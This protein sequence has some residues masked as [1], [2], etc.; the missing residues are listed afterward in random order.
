MDRYSVQYTRTSSWRLCVERSG[1]AVPLDQLELE[2]VAAILNAD[3]RKVA[4][5]EARLVRPPGRP[6]HAHPVGEQCF[7]PRLSY[8]HK[9]TEECH[10]TTKP[11]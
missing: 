3:A 4:L 9:K 11:V 2:A 5:E 7:C 1:R 6:Y 10:A 8:L